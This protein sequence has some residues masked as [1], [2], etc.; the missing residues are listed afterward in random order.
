MKHNR[1]IL[2]IDLLFCLLIIPL[3]ITLLPVERWLIHSESCFI[4]LIVYIYA[5]YL[6]YRSMHL[7]QLFLQKK[8]IAG[9]G[10]IGLLLAVTAVLT[11]IP[12]QIDISDATPE[13]RIVRQGLKRQTFWFFFLI[14]SGFSL[15]IELAIELFRLILSKQELE[16]SRDKAELELY[17]SQINPHF[18]FNT[19]NTLYA[20][21]LCQSKHTETAFVN[22]S[23][24]LRY[25]YS[26]IGEDLV[27]VGQEIEY[28]R[29]YV[30]LQKLRL[31]Q[32]TRV[33]LEIDVDDD[34]KRI[35][36]MMLITFV[37]NAF[38]YG[39]SSEIDCQIA[40]RIR[41]KDSMLSFDAENAVM[42]E[43][44]DDG[45]AAIGIENCRKRLD[46]LFAG[47]YQLD[48]TNEH[49]TYHTHLT[50]QLS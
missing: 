22:F 17:R 14:V 7:T 43:R 16:A 11:H 42:R 40:I 39:T 37:E 6:A 15:S 41:L 24:L 31:N 12:F 9:L 49:G 29:Q 1:I 30:D 13:Q 8:F 28:I 33:Q 25:T 27:P 35:P 38:K 45:N 44:S 32:H 50:I 46:L 36:P 2:Y 21:V 3:V 19:L 10:L 48:I 34:G 47:R 26:Q 4:A 5:L 18:L 20:L 23:N